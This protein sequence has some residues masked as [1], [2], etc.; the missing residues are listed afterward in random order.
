MSS[1]T[2]PYLDDVVQSDIGK[3]AAAAAA[4]QHT[5]SSQTSCRRRIF[6]ESCLLCLKSLAQQL[7]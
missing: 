5:T 4:V 3:P 7:H 2:S 1:L 6:I